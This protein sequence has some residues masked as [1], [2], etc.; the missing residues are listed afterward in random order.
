MG[1]RR[2]SMGIFQFADLTATVLSC[3]CISFDDLQTWFWKLINQIVEKSPCAF[4][5]SRART[6]YCTWWLEQ[7]LYQKIYNSLRALCFFSLANCLA[8]FI[9][10]EFLILQHKVKDSYYSTFPA[11]CLGF[12]DRMILITLQAAFPPPLSAFILRLK[13]TENKKKK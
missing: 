11:T 4:W 1:M 12:G 6:A 3:N 10:N 8:I 7:N 5:F 9:A 2:I 13:K